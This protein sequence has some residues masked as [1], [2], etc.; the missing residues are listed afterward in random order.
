MMFWHR[1]DL[2]LHLHFG[3][4]YGSL[5]EDNIEGPLCYPFQTMKYSEQATP[6]TITTSNI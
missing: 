6:L 1:S 4:M 5:K 3:E 2:D